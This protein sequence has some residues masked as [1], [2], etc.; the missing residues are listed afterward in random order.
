MRLN[1]GL[2]WLKKSPVFS[3]LFS[4]KHE[5]NREQ[6]SESIASMLDAGG[7]ATCLAFANVVRA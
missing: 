3:G 4:A 1:F 5:L 6:K 7:A 2:F